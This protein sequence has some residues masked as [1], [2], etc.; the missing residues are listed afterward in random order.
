MRSCLMCCAGWLGWKGVGKHNPL[1]LYTI[2]NLSNL[3]NL[4]THTGE[5]VQR[6][7]HAGGKGW[8]GWKVLFFS[9]GYRLETRLERVGKRLERL[10]RLL[11]INLIGSGT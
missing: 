7:S 2:S 11:V 9:A 4:Y 5:T 6:F 1:I 8:K 10:E 3:S